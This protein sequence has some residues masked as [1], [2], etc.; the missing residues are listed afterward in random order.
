MKS[1]AVSDGLPGE[2]LKSSL[3][4]NPSNLI[5][6]A[7]IVLVS[8][9]SY[10]KSL[11][12]FF[13]S[14]DLLCV[15][16]LYKIFNG[17]PQMLL[18]RMLSPWQD[19]SI[20]LL[21][22]PLCDLSL[23]LDYLIWATNSFG[24]HLT[25]LLMHSASSVVLYFFLRHLLRNSGTN[26]Q[27]VTV[28]AAL[29]AGIFA[30]SPLH[31]EP[32]LWIVCRADLASTV[33]VLAVLLFAS[34]RFCQEKSLGISVCILY[35][36]A[37]LFKESAACS[38]GI[39][40]ASLFICDT[41]ASSYKQK[42]LSVLRFMLPVLLVTPIY[43]VLRFCVLGTL[44][45]GYVGSLGDALS[46]NGFS[47][48]VDLDWAALI[49]LSANLVVF[50]SDC[51]ILNLLRSI[52]LLLA[53]FLLVR[54]VIAPWDART[55]TILSFLL[56]ASIMALVPAFQV[57]GVTPTLNNSRIF[58]LASAFII[59]L[60]VVAVYPLGSQVR[61]SLRLGAMISLS[62][63]LLVFILMCSMSLDPWVEGSNLLRSLQAKLALAMDK[64]AAL[65]V[66]AELLDQSTDKQKEL[67]EYSGE[68]H[69]LFLVLNFPA[70]YHG[71]HLMYEFRELMVLMGPAFFGQKN[72]SQKLEALDEY[73]DF[74]ASRVQRL[75]SK[76]FDSGTR[77]LW[78]DKSDS[79]LEDFH[80]EEVSQNVFENGN[81]QNSTDAVL[82]NARCDIKDQ[83]AYLARFGM[84]L[85]FTGA[86]QI[87]ILIKCKKSLKRAFIA[88]SFAQDGA[89]RSSSKGP[90][91]SGK[92]ISG[93]A[94]TCSD[95]TG[96]RTKSDTT[97]NADLPTVP[98][99]YYLRFD[100]GQDG[101]QFCR[102]SAFDLRRHLNCGPMSPLKLR[103]DKG[104][105]ILRCTLLPEKSLGYIDVSKDTITELRNGNFA[106][107]PSQAAEISLDVSH[108]DNARGM[109]LEIS[110]PNFQFN[111][112]KV[113][114][115][116]PRPSKCAARTMR[117]N[118]RSNVFRLQA[119]EMPPGA[120][121]Q[122]RVCATDDQGRL[123]G[124][125]S[126]P[127]T[128]DLRPVAI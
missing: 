118:E 6:V 89:N 53:A 17:Q 104:T 82:E 63:M 122:L 103:V 28:C 57:I 38:A 127:I 85:R 94:L 68:K 55:T 59:P 62:S 79:S 45:G 42:A 70:N 69:P 40:F 14:D 90:D 114:S 19:R 105:E 18:E 100:L 48:I 99:D 46:R 125:F 91:A 25:N 64:Q 116:D 87:E 78:F 120:F 61:R 23:A 97:G 1:S 58:Y 65:S 41:K 101:E 126:D 124:G 77:V 37:L 51:I 47:R 52:Y 67:S 75:Q 81:K 92:P 5:V 109:F 31:V 2:K 32:V 93:A 4:L 119:K 72:Y 36:A 50:P 128:F 27:D 43:F 123:I 117:I 16:Y 80:P 3:F 12:C 95:P 29:A 26:R 96:S 34:V 66:S 76:V 39:L 60:L 110:K 35:L 108:I 84:P 9:V 107:K 83:K 113:F 73:P 112:G 111:F 71:S 121:Y 44:I 10:W 20:S 88:M 22:R 98:D 30:A 11:S 54:A 102:I 33:L 106:F 74:V 15:D 7:G 24:F 86:D 49:G 115:H 8:F 56:I 13:F 21:Y